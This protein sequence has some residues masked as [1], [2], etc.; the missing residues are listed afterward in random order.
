RDPP[1]RGADQE[2]VVEGRPGAVLLV[3]EGEGGGAVAPLEARNAWF[4]AVR[5]PA[6]DRLIGRVQPGQHRLQ[7]LR[8]E[9]G[10]CGERGAQGR[11]LGLLL[12]AGGALA[13]PPPPPGEA[14]VQG[15]VVEH[16]TAPEHLLPL[17]LLLGRRLELLVVGSVCGR[18][19]GSWLLHIDAY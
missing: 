9:G 11:E 14:L 19:R 3:G 1:T 12:D 16:A 5:Q 15:G 10:V 8:V 2:A 4:L 17:A 6:E 7:D 13:L 18:H